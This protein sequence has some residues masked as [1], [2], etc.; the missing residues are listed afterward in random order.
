MEQDKYIDSYPQEA[1][2]VLPLPVHGESAGVR[3]RLG[4]G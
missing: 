1:L 4:S 2:Q 3:G